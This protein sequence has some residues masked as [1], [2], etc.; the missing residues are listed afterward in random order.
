MRIATWNVNSL[1]IRMPRVE[2]WLG[3]ANPDVLCLQETKLSDTTFPALAFS[4]LGYEAVHHGSGQWNGVAVLSRVGIEEVASGFA[5]GIE[6]DSETRLLTVRCGGVLVSS[7]YVPNGRSVDSDHYRYKL[8]WLGKLR[9]HLEAL[10]SP[11]DPVAVCGDFNIA[12]EDRDV[13]DPA[14]FKD[15]THVTEPERHALSDVEAWGL[16]DAF[17]ERYGDDALYTYWDYRAGDF[18]EHRGMRIDL[19]LLSGPLADRVTW[20]I[21]DRNARKGKLPSDHAPL[22][23]DIEA[24][25]T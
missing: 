11:D 12:P 17:R 23:V 3:Y 6:A 4:A 21:V 16:R 24:A 10:A 8:A 13:W 2:E 22:L 20:A 7:V 14:A 25:A 1:K 9:Q 5:T 15:S 19:V 18:H